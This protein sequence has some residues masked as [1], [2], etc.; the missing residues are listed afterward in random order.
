MNIFE[1]NYM[2]TKSATTAL[3]KD[4]IFQEKNS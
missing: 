3:E 1:K 4:F 2:Y